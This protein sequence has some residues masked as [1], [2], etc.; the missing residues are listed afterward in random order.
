MIPCP[1]A[2]QNQSMPALITSQPPQKL[3]SHTISGRRPGPPSNSLPFKNKSITV[4]P[5]PDKPLSPEICKFGVGCTSPRCTFS[6]PSPVATVLSGMV[7]KTEAC[8]KGK[9]C[10][11]PD[12]AYSHVSPAQKH[13]KSN[14]SSSALSLTDRNGEKVLRLTCTLLLSY[15]RYGWSLSSPL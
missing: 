7:L 8:P 15:R 6:H 1:L 5:S 9:E 10:E 14:K 3:G 4:G 11:D 13:G 2:L 12:C